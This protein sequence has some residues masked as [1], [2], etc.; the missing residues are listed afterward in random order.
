MNSRENREN[1]SQSRIIFN[2]YERDDIEGE[3]FVADHIFSYIISGKHEVWSGNELYKFEPGNYR[4]F[5]RNQLSKYV[6]RTDSKGFKSIA[7]HIDQQ[8][9]KMMSNEYGIIADRSHPG[10]NVELLKPNLYLDR[11][12]DS[13]TPY[14]DKKGAYYERI[15]SLKVEELVFILLETN[16]LLK[17][18]LF[19]F[20]EPGKIDLE[21]FMNTHYRYNEGIDRFAFLTGRSLSTFKRDFAAQF[22]TTPGKWLTK[23]RLEEA[24]YLIIE[25]RKVPS[26]IYLDLGFED[27]SH[28]SF[29]YKKAFG[30]TPSNDLRQ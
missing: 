27:L 11:Y 12:I 30:V 22:H 25:K 1:V 14:L 21:A 13:L 2:R 3:A 28:F 29:A 5:R 23:R 8:T 4:F 15:V 18:T 19:D 26:E 20:S 24:Q 7:V 10:S 16:P 9:L 17:H 6:K